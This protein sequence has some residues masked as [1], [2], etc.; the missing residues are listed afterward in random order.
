MPDE[1]LASLAIDAREIAWRS[2]LE[3][4]EEDLAPAWVAERDGAVVGY[5]VSGPPRDE[6]APPDAAEIYAIYVAP[7]QWRSGTGRALLGVAGAEWASRGTR[8]LVLWVFD[9]NARAR[10]FYEALG[11]TADGSRR[12]IDWGGFTTAEVR[13]R[14]PA[15]GSV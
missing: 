10:S 9:E 4:D 7:E 12:E 5:L 6:D 1:F 13:Y 8:T 15:N 3:S 2:R 14:R 11:W